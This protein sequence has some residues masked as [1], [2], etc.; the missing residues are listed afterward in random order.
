MLQF[1][2]GRWKYLIFLFKFLLFKDSNSNTNSF[3]D[4]QEIKE[5]SG[6]EEEDDEEE[7]GGQFQ[8]K[9]FGYNKFSMNNSS[10]KFDQTPSI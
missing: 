1:K 5:I 3:D 10:Q 9:D 2:F 4:L 6:D 8:I 7:D